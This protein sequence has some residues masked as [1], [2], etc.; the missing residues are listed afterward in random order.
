YTNITHEFR[1]PLTVILGMADLLKKNSKTKE[2][3]V[4]NSQGLLRLVNQILDLAKL[5]SGHLKLDMIQADIIP[6]LKYLMESLQSYAERTELTLVFQ[7]NA[8][9]LMMDFDEKKLEIITSNLLTNAIKFSEEGGKILFDVKQIKEQLIITVSDNGIGISPENIAHIFNRFYQVD[10]PNHKIKGSNKTGSGV[11]LTLTKEL[12]ELMGGNIK[13]DSA[14]DQGTTFT[15]SLPIS[16]HAPIVVQEYSLPLTPLGLRAANEKRPL[17][18]DDA[19]EADELPLLLL[20]EDNEDVAAYITACLQDFYTVD[21]AKNGA[22][23]IERAL[24]SI[25]DAIIS[26][27]M[28]PEKNGFEVCQKLKGDERTNHIPIILLTAKIDIPSRMEGL[29]AG[30]DAYLAKPF[31][32][33]ELLI[34][35]AKMVEL[36][37]SLQEKYAS[38]DF[39]ALLDTAQDKVDNSPEALFLKKASL[40][41]Q[42]HIDD[43]E[44]G[45]QELSQQMAMSESQLNRKIKALTDQ[46][47]S[48]FIR[49]IRLQKAKI[50]IETTSL[51]I[52]EVAYHV[53][54]SS[55]AYFSSTFSKRFGAAPNT[56]R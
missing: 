45:N 56:F 55:P 39:T 9:H 33:E 10:T 20:I 35:L 38:S 37:R 8:N 13:V 22:I 53:G 24:S 25:P 49:N 12:V 54:F 11:G 47:L 16:N 2:L 42:E 4:R 3:I 34:R 14:T 30:A 44:F 23:G 18:V 36:R 43:S 7:S 41:I 21:W 17:T 26:D 31:L 19:I 29:G 1:T 28:M 48:I 46:T 5:E 32:K 15:I 52:S 50:L 51:N 6:Y 27:V 40:I